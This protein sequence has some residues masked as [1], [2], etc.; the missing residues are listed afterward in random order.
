MSSQHQPLPQRYSTAVMT[1]ALIFGVVLC[2][3]ILEPFISSLVWSLTLAVLFAP[4]EKRIRRSVRSPGLSAAITLMLCGAILVAPIFFVSRALINEIIDSVDLIGSLLT[5]DHWQQLERKQPWLTPLMDW[6]SRHLDLPQLLNSATNLLGEWSAGVVQVSITTIINLL[7][8]FY[9]L[10]YLLRDQTRIR[11]A[12]ARTMPL[13]GDE[14]SVLAV[15]VVN[16]I[17]A[18]VYGTVAVALLQGFLA[19]LMFWFLGLPSPVFWGVIMGLLAIV[20]FL[21]AFIVWVPAC[22]LLALNGQWV[23]AIALAI[24]GTVVVGLIDNVIYPILVGRQL[25][26]HSMLSFIAI[27]GGLI[28]VGAH[29]I[30]L[31]PLIVS[32]S[33]GLLEIWRSRIDLEKPPPGQAPS[34]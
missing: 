13:T 7:L 32:L 5:G 26:M 17:Y 3:R 24:W 18:S 22:I 4:A 9:F 12:L 8:I 27:V 16:T 34:V 25:A 2:Y 21:G 11:H 6:L 31:G 28:M 33:L 29:G 20:P 1:I 19:G 14:F 23:S 15:R 30:I 10:F